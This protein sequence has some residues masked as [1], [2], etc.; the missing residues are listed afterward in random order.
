MPLDAVCI[1]ALA[2]ELQSRVQGG[3]IDRV[4]QPERD[5]LLLGLRAKGENLRLLIA[6]GTGNARVHVTEASFENPAEPP[7][8]CMLLRKHLV[9]ARILSV[10][11]PGWERMLCLE[12]LCH[13]ELGVESQKKLYVEMIGRSANTIL[14]DEDGHIIDCM[15][16]VDFA[17]DP[18]RRLLPGMLYRLPPRQDKPV[19]FEE[20]PGALRAACEKL[21]PDQ[22]IDRWLLDSY[23]GLSPLVCRELAYRC[24]GDASRLPALLEALQESVLAGDQTPTLLLRGGQPFDYSFMAIDQYGADVSLE[25]FADFSQLLDA[26]YTRR[27]RLEQQRRRSHELQRSIKTVHDRLARKLAN[28]R[29]ELRRTETREE[30]R[31]KAELIT[32]NLYRIKRGDRVL[33]CEDY[34]EPDAPEIEIPLDS[35]KTPQQNAAA[36]FKEY[37]KLK[38][39][40]QH[41]SLLVK[42][43]EEQLQYL[44][45]VLDAIGRAESE[46]D[47]SDIRRELTETGYLRKP[48]GGKPAKDRP[49]APLRF[50]TDDGLEVLV[51]RN[52]LQNDELTHKLA[53]RTDYWFHAQKIH[54]SHVILRCDGLEPPERSLLQAASLAA[55]YS[56]GRAAGRVPVDC[57]M[58][59]FVKK[60]AGALP[61]M[62]I[63][64]DQTTILAQ[65]DEALVRRLQKK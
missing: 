22:P 9:G 58:V 11:Q 56:Q 50:V 47:L 37:N 45:S 6:V 13:D 30:V 27:D 12:L 4:Q 19:F 42:Q 38:T 25:R 41:L 20:E 8:F 14:A 61:G 36:L 26:F 46:K 7:M 17:G 64:T 16:R 48:K 63:Y 44:G 18:L 40:Q 21:S 49:Q 51:G 65:A 2:D 29:E 34:Y 39:A 28:Q 5:M 55:W 10:T 31:R 1:S 32:A 57:T 54:G 35:L 62:V 24:G 3:R 52:N 23:A 43:G 53:R 59:R 60:P 15:R 33:R